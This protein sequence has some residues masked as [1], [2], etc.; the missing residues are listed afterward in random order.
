VRATALL[1]LLVLGLCGCGDDGPGTKD[2]TPREERGVHAGSRHVVAKDPS[3]PYYRDHPAQ[4]RPPDGTL[5]KGTVVVRLPDPPMGTYWRVHA[6]SGE[7]AW[8][9]S[10]DLAPAN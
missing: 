1:C 4:G 2:R 5:A 3:T 7:D 6:L 8:V 9:D 10:K